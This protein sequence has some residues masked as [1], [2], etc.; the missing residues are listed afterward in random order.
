MAA[1]KQ[2]ISDEMK[3]ALLSG[4]RFR[5]DV[6]RNAKATLLNEEVA[7]GKR[8]EG[9]ND[10]EV[11]KVLTREVKK[12]LEAAKL[13]RQNDRDEL[14]EPEEQE[15]AILQEFLPEQLGEDDI[16]VVVEEVITTM[17]NV[18]MQQMG[19]V[20]GAVKNFSLR[21]ITSRSLYLFCYAFLQ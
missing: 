2:R 19:Q 4:D 12:R 18:T 14:A 7:S 6:L 21:Q 9:L 20:I 15:A 17:D 13:Y 10:A 8:A 3:A 1:L 16:R 11:E 5:G